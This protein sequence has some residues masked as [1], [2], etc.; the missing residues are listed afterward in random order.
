MK[1]D[2]NQIRNI[3]DETW[4]IGYLSKEQMSQVSQSPI[5]AKFHVFG[6]DL[7][8][9]MHFNDITHG[10]VFLKQGHTWDYSHYKQI[11]DTLKSNKIIG[12]YP[13]YT[14]Y[15]D[16]AI[17]AGLGVRAKNSLVY[18]YKFGFDCHIATIGVNI[19][20]INQ[21]DKSKKVNTGLWKK[22]NGCNDCAVNCP[23]KAIHL[24]KEPYWIDGGAC[25]NFIF[26]GEHQR[27]PNVR[28]YWHKNVHPEY[29]DDVVKKVSYQIGWDKEDKI[30][31][32]I[33]IAMHQI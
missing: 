15:K 24:D 26:F 18:S 4:D 12:W 30:D 22:C 14:N 20:V 9:G 1:F 13:T 3:F 5:K 8:N 23:A 11:V 29:P 33:K 19:D 6:K 21:P 31:V 17:L 10:L 32:E 27:I 2:F 7:T 16:A 25:E 28:D